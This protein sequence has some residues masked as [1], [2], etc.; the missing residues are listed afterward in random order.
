MPCR[1]M[2]DRCGGGDDG[3]SVVCGLCVTGGACHATVQRFVKTQGLLLG[4]GM[5]QTAS[6]MS[7]GKENTPL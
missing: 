2:I 6:Y 4:G 1:T 7:Q 5:R 3:G